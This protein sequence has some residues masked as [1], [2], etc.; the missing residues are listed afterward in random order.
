MNA[1]HLE[2]FTALMKCESV[3][4]KTINKINIVLSVVVT[5]LLTVSLI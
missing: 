1:E 2:I 3:D 5:V 4:T